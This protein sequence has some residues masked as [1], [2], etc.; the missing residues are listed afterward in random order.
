MNGTIQVA[1]DAPVS[2]N[3]SIQDNKFVPL[4]LWFALAGLRVA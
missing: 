4:L 1:A 2:A 3:V